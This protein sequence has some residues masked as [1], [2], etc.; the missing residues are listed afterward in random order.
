MT[1]QALRAYLSA[2]PCP[3]GYLDFA[4]VGPLLTPARR[5]RDAAT[6]LVTDEPERL[7]DLEALAVTAAGLASELTGFSDDALVLSPSTSA[8]LFQVAFALPPGEVLVSPFDFP[9]NV[10][11]WLRAQEHGGARVR[12]LVDPASAGRP[13]ITPD[14]VAAALTPQ[15]VAV[16]VSAVDSY[17]GH[18]IDLEGLRAAIGDRLLIIDAI[19]AL[20]ALDL[21]WTAADV[22]ASGAQKWLRGGWGAG[23]LACSD[24]AL[25]RLGA[26]LVGWTGLQG[27]DDP[28]QPPRLAAPRRDVR[29]FSMTAPDLIAVAGLA[30]ALEG[31]RAAGIE[32]VSGRVRQLVT[33]C[34]EALEAAGARLEGPADPDEQSGIVTFAASGRPA[35]QVVAELAREG[36]TVAER[37]GYVRASLHASTTE[38]SVGQLASV[39]GGIIR[40]A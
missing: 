23:L 29:R 11:P 25:D 30:G 21:P 18:R 9:A 17:N 12:W 6:R 24:R 40:Q 2:S 8:A 38:D 13:R 10:Q 7:D 20:G 1:E 15:T 14:L 3:P 37:A 33:R 26:G 27:P 16:A 35:A 28:R 19:Q 4:R 34:R 36:I 5:A 31:L 22:V 39:V 32:A